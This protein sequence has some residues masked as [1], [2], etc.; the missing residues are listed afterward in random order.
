MKCTVNITISYS[1]WHKT[2]EGLYSTWVRDGRWEW[3][4]VPTRGNLLL[5]HSWLMPI[6]QI[7]L[8]EN[9]YRGNRISTSQLTQCSED[10]LPAAKSVS[11]TN[12]G[13]RQLVLRVRWQVLEYDRLTLRCHSNDDPVTWMCARLSWTY[14]KS[15]HSHTYYLQT[16]HQPPTHSLGYLLWIMDLIHPN[17]VIKSPDN[18]IQE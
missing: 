14:T 13:N 17:G 11:A 12:R 5:A 8:L 2:D 6:L 10:D 3:T 1:W 18:S 7:I 16:G 15:L 4:S 9:G